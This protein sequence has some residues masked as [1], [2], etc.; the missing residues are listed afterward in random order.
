MYA[1]KLQF[2]H[3]TNITKRMRKYVTIYNKS[4]KYCT[5]EYSNELESLK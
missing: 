4:K 1:S 3:K 5:G 2:A